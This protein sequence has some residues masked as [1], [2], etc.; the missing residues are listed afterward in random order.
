[1]VESVLKKQEEANF[2]LDGAALKV[3]PYIPPPIDDYKVFLSGV[4]DGVS[5]ESLEM[6]VEVVSGL[7]PV[8]VDYGETPGSVMLTFDEPP[9]TFYYI[10]FR[11]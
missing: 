11:T 6:F 5:R 8:A 1:M 3:R 7:S 4:R 2:K 9:G 10:L